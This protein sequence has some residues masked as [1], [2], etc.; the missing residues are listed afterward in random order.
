MEA[1]RKAA[2]SCH[3]S[4]SILSIMKMGRDGSN[5]AIPMFA[6]VIAPDITKI[7]NQ[8]SDFEGNRIEFLTGR[9]EDVGIGNQGLQTK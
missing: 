3:F 5:M 9:N 8:E 7:Y 4:A 1:G 2:P 6:N